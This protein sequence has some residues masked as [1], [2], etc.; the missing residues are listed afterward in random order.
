MREVPPVDTLMKPRASTWLAALTQPV[1]VYVLAGYFAVYV[2]F[3]LMP[4]FLNSDQV[5]QFPQYIPTYDPI[6]VDWRNTRANVEAWVTTGKSLDPTLIPYPPLGYLLPYPL[7]FVDAQT[8]FEVVTAV[9]VVAFIVGVIVVPLLLSGRNQNWWAIATFCLVTG[10]SS[11]GLHFELERGQFNVVAMSL[12]MLGIYCVRHKPKY[13]IWGYLLFSAS[14][15]L[16][17]YPCLFV[18]LFVTDWSKWARNLRG[19]GA[20]VAFNV[21]LLFALGFERFLEMLSMLRNYTSS[22]KIWVGNHSVHS[23]SNL[24]AESR[25]EQKSVWAELVRDAWSVQVLVLAIVLTSALVILLASMSRK[26]T[27]VDGALLLACTVLALVLPAVSH[28]YTLAL[29]AGPMAIYLGQV[30][31]FTDPKRQAVTNLLVLILSLA[32]SSTLFSYVYKPAWLGNNLP[33]LVIILVVVAV[34]TLLVVEPGGSS[35]QKL[36]QPRY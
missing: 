26:R 19:L 15:Q 27:G 5:M 34:M 7:L 29:L 1:I 33:M 12:C 32:Y 30:G 4:V 10:L 28:D 11:F 2:A 23:F 22:N 8:S 25:L 24:F 13:R 17:I 21:A 35:K 20:L 18:G 16:K 14:V 31:T 9:S 36:Y 6:G 3:F